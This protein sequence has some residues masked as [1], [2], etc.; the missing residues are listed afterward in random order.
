VNILFLCFNIKE[1]TSKAR[2]SIPRALEKTA[3]L[4]KS[5]GRWSCRH[6]IL[7]ERRL[8]LA[9]EVAASELT[10]HE[11]SMALYNQGVKQLH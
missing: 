7:G 10:L 11:T 9:G 8:H 3:D 1:A 6:P 4:P 5:S 2:R